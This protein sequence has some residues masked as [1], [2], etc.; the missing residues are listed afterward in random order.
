MVSSLPPIFFT[1]ALDECT[2]CVQNTS[3]VYVD[4]DNILLIGD[5]DVCTVCKHYCFNGW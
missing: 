4:C 5:V 2:S 3:L 1:L